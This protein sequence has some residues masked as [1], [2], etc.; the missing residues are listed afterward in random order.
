VSAPLFE[1]V[2]APGR[3]R[4]RIDE[5]TARLEVAAVLAGGPEATTVALVRQGLEAGV[6]DPSIIATLVRLG[7][8]AGSSVAATGDQRG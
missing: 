6:G 3:Y 4:V 7:V 2:L 5:R 8:D 1:V